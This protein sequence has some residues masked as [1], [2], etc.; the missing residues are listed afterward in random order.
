MPNLTMPG[1]ATLAEIG[2]LID[3]NRPRLT[4]VVAFI[5][6]KGGAGKTTCTANVGAATANMLSAIPGAKRVLCLELDGQ[7]NLGLDL[8]YTR[9]EHDDD[10]ASILAVGMGTG[11]FNVIRDV[12]RNLDVIPGGLE[13]P[14]LSAYL[15]VLNEKDRKLARLRFSK[16]LADLAGEYEWIWIDCPPLD[17]EIQVLGLVAARWMVIP[18]QFDRASRFGLE[19]VSIA[20]EEASSL[21]PEL[22]LLGVLMFGFERRE[23]RPSKEEEGKTR[24]IGQRARVRQKLRDV[25]EEIGSD[26]PIF[27]AVVSNARVVAEECREAGIV[28]Y[29]MA[30]QASSDTWR[31]ER[32]SRGEVVVDGDVAEA[33]ASDYQ[34]VAVEII[35]NAREREAA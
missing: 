30:D 11:R 21:N 19:G 25:L 4:R 16:A 1:S 28:S 6:G 29:E 5:N 31:K 32:R 18:A 17:E 33:L 13:V 15:K 2:A 9:T 14:K 12:R 27:D 7:G 23:V 34:A 20:L 10:G 26:A 35:R 3:S 24:E 8:G 22:D